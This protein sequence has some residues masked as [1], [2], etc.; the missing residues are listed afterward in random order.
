MDKAAY[1]YEKVESAKILK[2]VRDSGVSEEDYRRVKKILY[3]HTDSD[4]IERTIKGLS[5]EDEFAL[6]ELLHT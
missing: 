2:T 3:P 5:E 6:W 1:E 4:A